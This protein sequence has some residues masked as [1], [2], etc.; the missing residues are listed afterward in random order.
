MDSKQKLVAEMFEKGLLLNEELLRQDLN[1]EVLQ[2]ITAEEDLLVLNK[3]YTEIITQQTSLVDWYEIDRLH[4]TDHQ[5]YL[6]NHHQNQN[7]RLD[8]HLVGEMR[9]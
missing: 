2:K 6:R 9:S 7:W 4:R 5:K 3:D 8:R 1:E